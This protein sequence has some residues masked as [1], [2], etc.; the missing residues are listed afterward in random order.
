MSASDTRGSG[1]GEELEILLRSS[2][3]CAE[4]C[5]APSSCSL[6]SAKPDG[7]PGHLSVM[8]SLPLR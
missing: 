1:P 5:K 2:Q 7:Q 4:A 8:G 3:E 6:S